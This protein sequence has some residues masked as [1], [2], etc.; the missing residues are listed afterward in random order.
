MTYDF[1]LFLK[2]HVNSKKISSI[3]ENFGYTADQSSQ[4]E[5]CIL[6]KRT[7]SDEL[8]LVRQITDESEIRFGSQYLNNGDIEIATAF[9]FSTFHAFKEQIEQLLQK[10]VMQI[11]GGIFDP[12][13]NAFIFP[14][15]ELRKETENL[16]MNT[17][18]VKW[19]FD[20]EDFQSKRIKWREVQKSFYEFGNS[21]DLLSTADD[22]SELTNSIPPGTK[23]IRIDQ[24]ISPCMRAEISMPSG[25]E[26]LSYQRAFVSLTLDF[27]FDYLK[28][29][30]DKLEKLKRMFL[31][32]SKILNCFYAA[33]FV[34]Q[35]MN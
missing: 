35:R 23:T 26:P 19:L 3:L 17:L 4:T 9:S 30:P 21:S 11:G 14:Q 12:Q 2:D 6:E 5:F 25:A 31:D 29:N 28:G 16:K 13:K 27:D 24:K 33:V 18:S 15:K 22:W 10:I 32:I 34:R 1:M 7:N 20:F 8:C